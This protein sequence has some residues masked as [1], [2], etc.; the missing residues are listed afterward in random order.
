MQTT[1]NLESKKSI[2]IKLNYIRDLFIR[3]EDSLALKELDPVLQKMESVAQ[4]IPA[5]AQEMYRQLLLQ[6]LQCLETKNYVR[7]I[8]ILIFEINPLFNN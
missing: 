4:G 5:P 7:L 8:D 1:N 2:N 3:N 6:A